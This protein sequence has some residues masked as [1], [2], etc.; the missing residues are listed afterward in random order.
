MEPGR[1]T[2]KIEGG[3]P[4]VKRTKAHLLDKWGLVEN[5]QNRRWKARG[6]AGVKRTKAHL[7]EK[8]GLVEKHA[9]SRVKADQRAFTG[10]IRLGRKFYK[11]R[12]CAFTGAIR[13]GRK[14]YKSRG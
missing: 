5:L 9:K 14:I 8:R 7:L 10:A 2:C 6:G 12:G 3:G 4:G 13:L 1:K 11:S